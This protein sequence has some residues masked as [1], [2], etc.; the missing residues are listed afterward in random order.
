MFGLK[1]DFLFGKQINEPG[2]LS[3]LLYED[4]TLL[5]SSGIRSHT[6]P[7]ERGYVAALEAGRIF[8]T[9]SKNPNDG[10]LALTS[11]GF[12]QH[13]IFISNKSK[14][15]PQLDGEYLKGY[16]RLANG[17]SIEEFV[18]YTHFSYPDMF[19]FTIGINILA[20]FTQGRRDYLFALWYGPLF[21]RKS[22]D[23]YFE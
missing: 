19:N 16:D 8:K 23:Y 1:T 12:I 22:E 15:I 11:L 21:R 10:I 5:S 7:L 17:I 9:S 20:G 2:F 14:D 3:N 13:K 4:G 18:G 6:I